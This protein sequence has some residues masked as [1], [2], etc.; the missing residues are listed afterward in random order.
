M[1][2]SDCVRRDSKHAPAGDEALA[3]LRSPRAGVTNDAPSVAFFFLSRRW[4]VGI[5]AGPTAPCNLSC[6]RCFF[7][8]AVCGVAEE[9]ASAGG[10]ARARLHAAV[11]PRVPPPLSCR[12]LLPGR[13][14]STQP[15]SE[16]VTAKCSLVGDPPLKA[17]SRYTMAPKLAPPTRRLTKKTSLKPA[18]K[19]TQK[20]LPEPLV[21]DLTEKSDAKLAVY[22]LTFPHPR[23]ARSS[24]GV[25]LVP[26]ESMTKESL[27]E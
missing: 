10:A 20:S 18:P 15:A 2:T 1:R 3:A 24:C 21:L 12:C 14:F 7:R 6:G 27:G 23:A 13:S 22:L 11:L 25:V 9:G 19:A 17:V 26:P 16:C 4:L 5:A 8:C